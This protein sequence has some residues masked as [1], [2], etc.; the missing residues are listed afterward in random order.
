MFCISAKSFIFPYNRLCSTCII[1]YINDSPIFPSVS[2]QCFNTQVLSAIDTLAVSCLQHFFAAINTGNAA[3][4]DT[5][6]K[7]N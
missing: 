1:L 3:E 5:E 2:W 7:A 4:L 6:R